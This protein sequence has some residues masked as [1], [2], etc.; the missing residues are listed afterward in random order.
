MQRL[1]P[2]GQ[3]LDSSWHLR[4]T[5]RRRAAMQRVIGSFVKGWR[6][7]RRGAAPSTAAVVELATATCEP[8]LRDTAGVPSRWRLHLRHLAPAVFHGVCVGANMQHGAMRNPAVQLGM[9][10][11]GPVRRVD[12]PAPMRA[13]PVGYDGWRLQP[14]KRATQ[15]PRRHA[16]A[17]RHTRLPQGTRAVRRAA[18]I[19]SPRVSSH[20]PTLRCGAVE[21]VR[22]T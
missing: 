10:Q 8:P 14:A 11:P 2:L 4:R 18:C 3:L 13:A 19:V 7:H 20:V 1:F 21:W 5:D 15:R 6:G 12:A 9:W 17:G 22:R 16:R